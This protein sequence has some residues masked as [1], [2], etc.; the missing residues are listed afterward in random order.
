MRTISYDLR[1]STV[2]TPDINPW[3]LRVGLPRT[4]ILEHDLQTMLYGNLP[5]V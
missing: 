3:G 4:G 2:E 1:T 5:L